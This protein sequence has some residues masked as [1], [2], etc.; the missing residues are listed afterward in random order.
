MDSMPEEDDGAGLGQHQDGRGVLAVLVVQPLW[1]ILLII[2][3][4]IMI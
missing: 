3:L 2:H 1:Y 4:N